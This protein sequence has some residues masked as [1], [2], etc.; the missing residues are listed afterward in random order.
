M[1]VPVHEFATLPDVDAAEILLVASDYEAFARL[2]SIPGQVL[3]RLVGEP[4]RRVAALW[5]SLPTAEQ[6]RCH[7]PRYGL[8]FFAAGLVLEAALCFECNN[9]SIVENGERRWATFDG[10]AAMARELLSILRSSDPSSSASDE[11]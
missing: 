5:R 3:T 10:E 4:A 9:I 11:A 8:R 6:M 1:P 2:S 7:M